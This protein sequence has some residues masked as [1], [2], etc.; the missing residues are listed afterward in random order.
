MFT[1][2]ST[3]FNNDTWKENQEK[4]EK[5]QIPC[6]YGSPQEMSPK[7]EYE[8]IVFVVEMNNTQNKIEGIGLIKNRPHM[9]K[10]YKI[11]V[12]GNYNRFIYKSNYRIDRDIL[13]RHNSYLVE[14]L[15][16]ILFKGKTHLKR[17][18]GFTTITDKLLKKEIC[19]DFDIRNAIRNIFISIYKSSDIKVIES[20]E[21]S[22]IYENE[23]PLNLI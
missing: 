11:H 18:C 4:R 5:L 7:I 6:F 1:V 16:N 13:I 12:D 19:K 3:R 2:V 17:G 21:Y 14:L 22:P 23:S 8:S 9:D 10:Y 20:E 15:D